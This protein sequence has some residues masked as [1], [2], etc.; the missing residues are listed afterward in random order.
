M[1]FSNTPQGSFMSTKHA[2]LKGT[3]ILTLTGFATRFIGFFYRVFL[4]HRFGEE[5]V[6]L[7]QLIFPVYALCFSLTTAG[8]QTAISRS[9]AHKV[10][11]GRS[12]QAKELLYA[13]LGISIALSFVVTYFL[14]QNAAFIALHMLS[15]PRTEPL[16]IAVSY[17]LPFAA[18]HSC[19]IGYHYGLK[20]TKIPAIAQMIEQVIRV[21]AVYIIYMIAVHRSFEISISIAVYGLVIGE[22]AS[23]FICIRS[24]HTSG[25]VRRKGFFALASYTKHLKEISTQSVPLTANRVLINLLHSIE[26]ISI[27][28]RLQAHGASVSSSLSTYGVLTGMAL[29]LILFPSAITNSVSIMLLPTVAEVQ[30]AKDKQEMKRL[31]KKVTLYCFAL[32]WACTIVFLVFGTWMGRILFN[33]E[34]TGRFIVTMAWICPFLYT[35][36]TL[37]SI[38]NGLGKATTSFIINSI[39]L[40]LRIGSVFFLIPMFGIAGYLWGLLASQLVVSALCL[41][42]L[43]IYLNR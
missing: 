39:G 40:A 37:I 4:S 23:A 16:V 31:V 19:I 7:Y 30:A 38:I 13:G 42:D 32:G 12:Q 8:I 1:Y 10:S 34:A 9:V 17:G 27:P 11:L 26:A 22:F 15:E 6:G 41:I 24:L 3:F 35:N 33:S 28:G 36:T 29:P 25:S 18:I 21:T 5:G 14:Q 2:I 20:Q 43:K